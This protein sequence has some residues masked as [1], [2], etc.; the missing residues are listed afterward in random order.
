M[1]HYTDGPTDQPWEVVE[2]DWSV[3]VQRIGCDA[4]ERANNWKMP[5]EFCVSIESDDKSRAV[6]LAARLNALDARTAALRRLCEALVRIRDTAKS[7]EGRTDAPYWNL[8]DIAAA[9]IKKYEAEQAAREV[10]DG[11]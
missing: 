6:Y 9:A 10:L 4:R 3:Y 5:Y 7:W 1:T 2:Q 8:G 11:N